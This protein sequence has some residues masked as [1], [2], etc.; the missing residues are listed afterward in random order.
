MNARTFLAGTFSAAGENKY[1]D[2]WRVILLRNS[3]LIKS[4][5]LHDNQLRLIFTDYPI[6]A[7]YNEVINKEGFRRTFVCE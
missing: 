5:H 1:A 2:V 4:M 6:N 7:L 3:T